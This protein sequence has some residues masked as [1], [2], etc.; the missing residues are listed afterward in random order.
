M[1]TCAAVGMHAYYQII[2]GAQQ[3][4]DQPR[5][6]QF[7]FYDFYDNSTYLVF[8]QFHQGTPASLLW[9]GQLRNSSRYKQKLKGRGGGSNPLSVTSDSNNNWFTS[10]FSAEYFSPLE[11]A[12]EGNQGRYTAWQWECQV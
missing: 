7:I 10:R 11:G 1:I 8:H 5:C 3:L 4:V 2:L 9:S 12:R 6:H